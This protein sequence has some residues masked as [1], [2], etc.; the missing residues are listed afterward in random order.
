M[1]GQVN[2]NE[3]MISRQ[4]ERREI[5]TITVDIGNAN[6]EQANIVIREGDEPMQLA[7]EFAERHGIK[8]E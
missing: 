3:M 4:N 6:G 5:L 1:R 7:F 8:S 2:S